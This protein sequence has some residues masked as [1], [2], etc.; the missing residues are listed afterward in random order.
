MNSGIAETIASLRGPVLV[1]GASGFIGA[2]LLRACLAV[3]PDVHG[4]VFS[5]GSWRL[6]GLPA[7]RIAHLNLLDPVSVASKE[8]SPSNE[9]GATR[10]LSS[11]S[12]KLPRSRASR[13]PFKGTVA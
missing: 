4:T 6:E 12:R 13:S 5:G 9:D 10:P 8:P 7:D 11:G 2:N 3:R 1:I